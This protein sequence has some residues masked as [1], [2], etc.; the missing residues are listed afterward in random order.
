[1]GGAIVPETKSRNLSAFKWKKGNW[2]Y[3]SIQE[4]P[5]QLQVNDISGLPHQRC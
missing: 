2:Q 5:F 1:M 3:C 4:T